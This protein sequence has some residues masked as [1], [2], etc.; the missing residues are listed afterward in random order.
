MKLNLLLPVII[1]LNLYPGT[2][3]SQIIKQYQTR[4]SLRITDNEAA[5]IGRRIWN[6]ESRGKIEGLTS[7]NEGEDFAS[8]GIAHFIWYPDGKTGPFKETFPDFT[9]FLQANGVKLPPFMKKSQ[10]CPWPD[11]QTFMKNFNSREMLE[12][13]NLLESTISHQVR[14]AAIRL[15]QALP[16][17]KNAATNNFRELIEERFYLVAAKPGGLYALMDYVNFKGEGISETERYQGHGWGLLQVLT[18]MKEGNPLVEFSKAAARVLQ[19]RVRSSPPE[20]NESRWLKGWINRCR[21]YS[22]DN[23]EPL[24]PKDHKRQPE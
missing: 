2:I 13:R 14:F 1:L 22:S 9:R 8:L 4:H 16:Q 18:E 15:E 21:T 24:H 11:R 6:N 23:H 19:R 5:E 17:M 10:R 12:L 20:R 7:W 3:S